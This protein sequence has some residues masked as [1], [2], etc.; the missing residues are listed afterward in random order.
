MISSPR[1][2]MSA[3]AGFTLVELMVA[4]GLSMLLGVALIKM[5]SSM[6]KQTMV[7]SDVGLRDTQS[8]AAADLLTQD[9]SSAGF[10]FGNTET[11]CAAL[12]TYNTA[13]YFIGHRVD[14]V[15][16]ST[17]ATLPFAPSLTLNYPSGNEASVSSDVLVI[18]TNTSASLFSDTNNPIIKTIP[19]TTLL[20][21][22]TGV[23]PVQSTTGLTVSDAAVVETPMTNKVLCMRVP[24][25]TTAT[26]TSM[27]SSV[28]ATMPG[29]FYAGFAAQTAA[30]GFTGTLTNAELY[31]SHVT[32]IGNVTSS[33]GQ[34]I[35]YYI[36]KTGT[37]ALPTL[38]RAAYSAVDDSLMTGSPQAIAVGVIA[39][40]VRFG[41]D[42]GG[43]VSYFTAAQVTTNKTWDSVVSTRVALISRTITPNADN[44]TSATSIPMSA[45]FGSLFTVPYAGYRFYD[46]ETEIFSRNQSWN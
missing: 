42:S 2:R 14:A 23:L 9:L 10:L 25:K 24:I 39:L 27:T 37:P 34:N 46:T 13:G 19:S 22:T 45:A 30:A 29:N 17:T 5:Q 16:A 36:Q 33:T 1:S 26:D 44:A 4:L 8:R 18:Q 6:S 43:A 28:N 41:V 38:M 31:Q 35:V 21:M 3:Q 32:D 15:P 11:H 40:Q 20:P 12:M 7:N